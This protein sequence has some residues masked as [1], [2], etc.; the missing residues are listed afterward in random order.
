MR[1]VIQIARE[2]AEVDPDIPRKNFESRD[3]DLPSRY[4]LHRGFPQLS[5]WQMTSNP[6][7]ITEITV[8]FPAVVRLCQCLHCTV[9]KN[10]FEQVSSLSFKWRN[11]AAEPLLLDKIQAR[12]TVTS[13]MM[14]AFNIGRSNVLSSQ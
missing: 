11:L 4:R 2:A 3:S 13:L 8:F 12:P 9:I 1:F 7:V 6:I 5:C 10:L 14:F